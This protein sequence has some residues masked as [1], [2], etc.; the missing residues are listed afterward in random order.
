MEGISKEC[1]SKWNVHC[2]EWSTLARTEGMNKS[3]NSTWNE[4]KG[5][6]EVLETRL[7]NLN[8]YAMFSFMRP[9]T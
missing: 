5:K 9:E 7:A 8:E 1:T 2:K 4:S 6:M 3:W